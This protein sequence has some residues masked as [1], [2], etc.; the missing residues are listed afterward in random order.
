MVRAGGV[1]QGRADALVALGDQVLITQVLVGGIAPVALAHPQ[2]EQLRQGLGQAV[3]QGLEHEGGVVVVLGLEGRHP[4][5][6][7]D[8]G[9]AGEAPQIVVEAGV[10]GG[11]EVAQ[12]VVGLARRLAALLA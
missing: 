8:A 10:E 12:A 1:A 4:G 6:D 5:V 9:G 3:G 2:V 7:A 11:D